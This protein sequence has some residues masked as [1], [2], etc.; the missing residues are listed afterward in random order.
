M[1]QIA[2]F[3]MLIIFPAIISNAVAQ[4]EIKAG[5]NNFIKLPG[6]SITFPEKYLNDKV[7]WYITEKNEEFDAVTIEGKRKR[8]SFSMKF[9]LNPILSDSIRNLS[10]KQI[11]D[12][13]RK[14]ELQAMQLLGVDMGMYRLE[15]VQQTEDSVG[16]RLFYTLFYANIMK[17]AAVAGRLHVH[18]PQQD[19]NDVLFVALFA[20]GMPVSQYSKDK[21]LE[22]F[23][24]FREI[25][26]SL[27]LNKYK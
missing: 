10:P 25:L 11:A 22:Y 8:N 7:K 6:F 5:I 26:E 27:V 19:K 14:Q 23:G 16:G 13:F 4:E 24:V 17:E 3:L 18:L 21:A 15:D 9:F 20:E 12:D 2:R 1:K